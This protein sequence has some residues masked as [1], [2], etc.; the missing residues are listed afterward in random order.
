[1][2]LRSFFEQDNFLLLFLLQ[3]ISRDHS[4]FS[5]F[6]YRCVTLWLRTSGANLEVTESWSNR[7]GKWWWHELTRE[8]KMASYFMERAVGANKKKHDHLKSRFENN[9]WAIMLHP[10]WR[11]S[12]SIPIKWRMLNNIRINHVLKK[13]KCSVYVPFI[14]IGEGT[15]SVIK[16]ESSWKIKHCAPKLS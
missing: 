4:K 11:Y 7:N 14:W 5:N 9:L 13:R 15:T 10:A 1:M 6:Y 2:I 16:M 8:Q 12:G 3:N